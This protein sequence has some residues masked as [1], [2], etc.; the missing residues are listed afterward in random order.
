MCVSHQIY[1][2]FLNIHQ[3]KPSDY[4]NN[5]SYNSVRLN[6][7]LLNETINIEKTLMLFGDITIRSQEK[8]K[9]ASLHSDHRVT[10]PP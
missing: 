3:L 7:S 10:I 6:R 8:R 5:F 4:N 2:F 1:L 9:N